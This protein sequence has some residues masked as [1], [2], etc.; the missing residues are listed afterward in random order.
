[1]KI[2]IVLNK[3]IS[4]YKIHLKIIF[5][6]YKTEKVSRHKWKGNESTSEYTRKIGNKQ[7]E[8]VEKKIIHSYIYIYII[9]NTTTT[10]K[11]NTCL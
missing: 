10:K 2:Y 5:S 11:K 6:N 7:V 1:M 4:I 8:I 9:T 3:I